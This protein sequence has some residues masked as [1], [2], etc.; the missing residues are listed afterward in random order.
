MKILHSK[1]LKK[2]II[3][4]KILDDKQLLI[5]DA[6]STVRYLDK[7]NFELLSGFKVGIAHLRYKTQ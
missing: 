4:L 3:S 6:E 2:P 1:S 5:V 7:E